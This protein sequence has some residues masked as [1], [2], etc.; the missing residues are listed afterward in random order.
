[1]LF[2]VLVPANSLPPATVNPEMCC[3]FIG[4]SFEL[5]AIMV[6]TIKTVQRRSRGVKWEENDEVIIRACL[7]AAFLP[8]F[9]FSG[10][11]LLAGVTLVIPIIQEFKNSQTQRL[12]P[13]PFAF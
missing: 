5:D 8:P 7:V 9:G 13:T 2:V 4:V 11:Q 3:R 6:S 12:L 1:M 10:Y